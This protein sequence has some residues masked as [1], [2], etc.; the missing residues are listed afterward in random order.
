V[1]TEADVEKMTKEERLEAIHML[2]DSMRDSSG[3]E[4]ESPGWHEEVLAE[5]TARIDAGEEVFLTIPEA[6][7]QV[8][9]FKAR[10]RP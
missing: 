6:K 7:A 1:I 3:N 9:E 8:A 5:R 10:H 4:P 2:W